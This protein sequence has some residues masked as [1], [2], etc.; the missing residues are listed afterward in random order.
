VG[1]TAGLGSC[2]KYHPSGIR[3]PDLQSL[4][5]RYND[6]ATRPEYVFCNLLYYLT[7]NVVL[8]CPVL[9]S[10]NLNHLFC[11]FHH[12]LEGTF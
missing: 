5:S 9:T 1:L 7:H 8:S 10:E 6:Y 3:S 11:V 12:Y 2:G 4:G